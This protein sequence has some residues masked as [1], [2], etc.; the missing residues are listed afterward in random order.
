MKQ[1][2]CRLSDELHEELRSRSFKERVS[3][4]ELIRRALEE[5]YQKKGEPRISAFSEPSL[6]KIWDNP[7]DA[8]YDDL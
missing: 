8:A 6:M 4:A 3:I 2:V 1:I 7:E 5:R